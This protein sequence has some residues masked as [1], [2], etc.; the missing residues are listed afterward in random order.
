MQL[1]PGVTSNCITMYMLVPGP[2]VRQQAC[3]NFTACPTDWVTEL[4]DIHGACSATMP[5]DTT[6]TLDRLLI[7]VHALSNE[8]RRH[9]TRTKFQLG[10]KHSGNL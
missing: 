7:L 4:I 5:V 10:N 1:T 6:F 2:A 9:F 8:T 3:L